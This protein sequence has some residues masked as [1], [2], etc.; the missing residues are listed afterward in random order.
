MGG[1]RRASS[2]GECFKYFAVFKWSVKCKFVESLKCLNKAHIKSH[3][4]L[5]YRALDK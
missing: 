3:T 1:H 4:V 5:H 2:T